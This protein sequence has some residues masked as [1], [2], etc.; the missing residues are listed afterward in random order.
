MDIK[1]IDEAYDAIENIE[2]LFQRA[3]KMAMILIEMDYGRKPAYTLD[4]DDIYIES[5]SLMAT[6][7]DT[8]NE[9][10]TKYIN[11]SYLF[12]DDWESDARAKIE[13]KREAEELKKI[14]VAKKREASLESRDYQKYLKFKERFGHI[15][16]EKE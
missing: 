13:A 3:A 14:S 16:E 6:W 2:Q 7:I 5:G 1:T 4:S 10:M 15:D 12:D 11:L 9:T 8:D